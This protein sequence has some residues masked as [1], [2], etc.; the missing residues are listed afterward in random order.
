M[1]LLMLLNYRITG[2]LHEVQIFTNAVLLTLAEIFTIEKFTTLSSQP[3]LIFHEDLRVF[4]VTS[5]K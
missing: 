3:T 1:F 5:S 2:Y 4:V